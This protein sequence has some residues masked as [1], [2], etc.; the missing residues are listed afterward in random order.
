MDANH[1]LANTTSGIEH[2]LGGHF[3]TKLRAR[4]FLRDCQDDALNFLPVESNLGA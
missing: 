4:A 1:F 3:S 2:L